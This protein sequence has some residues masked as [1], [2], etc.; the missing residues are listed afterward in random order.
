MEGGSGAG[1]GAEL[2]P[3]SATDS[4]AASATASPLQTGSQ[5]STL[6]GI[7]AGAGR[8]WASQ[9]RSG[10]SSA[11]PSTTAPPPPRIADL[12]ADQGGVGR[13][14]GG[15]SP[16]S[17]GSL[18]G[19]FPLLTSSA[20]STAGSASGTAP[21]TDQGSPRVTSSDR[22]AAKPT[23][24]STLQP[25]AGEVPNPAAASTE[26]KEGDSIEAQFLLAD[27]GA[28]TTSWYRGTVSK[29]NHRSVGGN[30]GEPVPKEPNAGGQEDGESDV[31]KNPTG[32]VSY[33]VEF[34]DGDRLDEVP[35]ERIRLFRGLQVGRS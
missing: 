18:F 13:D 26:L 3:L 19:G 7:A 8:S 10:E 16:A 11:A 5:S 28:W 12:L 29:V 9:F 32:G 1:A 2:S 34:V 33:A 27:Q 30:S 31:A 24:P 20:S 22:G 6:G 23:L 14:P 4:A 25:R 35:P 21:G 15:P 17:P